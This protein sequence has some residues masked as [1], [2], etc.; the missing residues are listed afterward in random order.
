MNL[1]TGGNKTA[2]SYELIIKLKIER[3]EHIIQL[4]IL[5]ASAVGMIILESLYSKRNFR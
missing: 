1:N 2:R 4:G 5:R 3:R